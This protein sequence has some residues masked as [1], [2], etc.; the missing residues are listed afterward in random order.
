[1][2]V[3]D[4]QY[5]V[6]HSVEDSIQIFVDSAKRD[7]A[8]Y[9][10]PS[11]YVVDFPDPFR[12]VYG[13]EIMD[14]SIPS[15][16]YNV[17]HDSNGLKVLRFF[18]PSSQTVQTFSART[19]LGELGSAPA[20]KRY[21][22][23]QSPSS[24]VFTDRAGFD[25]AISAGLSLAA[26]VGVGLTK[27]TSPYAIVVR[28]FQTGA[29]LISSTTIASSP[30]SFTF[31]VGSA[32]YTLTA[33]AAA[34]APDLAFAL[35][36]D[37]AVTLHG[38]SSAYD[39]GLPARTT[40][41]YALHQSIAQRGTQMYDVTWFAVFETDEASVQ[42][43]LD[44]GFVYET[45]LVCSVLALDIGN[46]T[47]Q[48]F[49]TQV[50][51]LLRPLQIQAGKIGPLPITQTYRLE[52]TSRVEFAFDMARST[53]RTALGFDEYADSVPVFDAGFG[54]PLYRNC[55]VCAT[56]GS[57]RSMFI[58][59][60]SA[61]RNAF[62]LAGPGIVTLQGVRYVKLR[63]PEIESFQNSATGTSEFNTGLGIFKLIGKNEISQIRFDFVK[64]HNR[65]IHPIGKLSRLTFRF[66]QPDGRL[67][68][69]KGVNHQLLINVKVWVPHPKMHYHGSVLNREYN[70]DIMK[71]MNNRRDAEVAAEEEAGE[72]GDGPL[73][74]Q[75]E[76][77]VD[78]ALYDYTTDEE[79]TESSDTEDDEFDAVMDLREKALR[80][81][82]ATLGDGVCGTGSATR[83]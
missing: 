25:A 24:L 50:A 34:S 46:Y 32:E 77:H 54:Q 37:P 52:F 79:A 2:A 27:L 73:A 72:P 11:N 56:Y 53:L 74:P 65:K 58:S 26:P 42:A 76:K 6:D 82:R 75:Q 60:F 7:R 30:G 39:G 40:Y 68:D 81:A 66:E 57:N 51:D 22:D 63:C 45:R 62:A 71:Y 13:V 14:G 41:A 78:D 21:I 49:Q 64:V 18:R 20:M 35:E 31:S 55:K 23:D 5:L 17:D 1:M 80:Q 33:A 38:N 67:Y 43:Y 4:V 59:V 36:N 83:V 19:L 47:L 12:N 69:F 61:N 10:T 3:E 8:F 9:P 70:P 48:Q 44:G 16:M 15:S 28:G 29:C